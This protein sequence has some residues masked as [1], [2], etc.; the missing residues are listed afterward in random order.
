M[1][2][3]MTIGDEMGTGVE[4][5]DTVGCTGPRQ[6]DHQRQQG[7]SGRRESIE[8]IGIVDTVTV[9]RGKRGK[10][11]VHLSIWILQILE[12]GE[13]LGDVLGFFELSSSECRS[14]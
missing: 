14:Y 9:K 11:Q 2:V 7:V 13:G 6:S 5:K 12:S 4:R 3:G 10:K 1:F 8:R